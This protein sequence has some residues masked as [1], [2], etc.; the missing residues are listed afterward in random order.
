MSSDR[1]NDDM[2]F[3]HQQEMIL[4]LSDYWENTGV[5]TMTKT[6]SFARSG[7]KT[8]NRVAALFTDTSRLTALATIT[9][10]SGVNATTTAASK[11][12]FAQQPQKRG[13]SDAHFAALQSS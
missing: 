8:Q 1:W 6:S 5:G 11:Q 12:I 4:C 7:R 13:Y 3:S 9:W 10:V 2:A